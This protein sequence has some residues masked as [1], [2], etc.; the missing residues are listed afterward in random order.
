MAGTVRVM[1]D[2][3]PVWDMGEKDLLEVEVMDTPLRLISAP[4]KGYFDILRSKLN[5]GGGRVAPP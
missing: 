4:R 1:V 2:G 5:W 3:R